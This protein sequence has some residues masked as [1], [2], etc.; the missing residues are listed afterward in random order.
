VLR[1]AC[2]AL[3]AGL[4]VSGCTRGSSD[5]DADP[6]PATSGSSVPTTSGASP[7]ATVVGL[8]P[9]PPRSA[10][11]RLAPAELTLP[12]NDSRPVPCTSP[13][14]A[15]TVHVGRLDTVVDGHSVA[16]GSATVQRQLSTA[17]PRRMAAFI[18]G[19]E[20][21]RR[22]SRF[23]VA[24]FSPTLGQS[25]RG[26]DWFRCDLVA[27]ARAE[28]LLPLPRRGTLEGVLDRPRALDTYGLCGTAAFGDPGFERVLCGR[29]HAWRAIST[30]DLPGGRRYPGAARLRA[31][32]DDVCARRARKEAAAPLRLTSGW[33]WPTRPQ[34]TSGQRYG[35]CW[36]PDRSR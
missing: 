25:D 29:P 9:P 31:A 24:W 8:P 6:S 20:K 11:Y 22:L 5:Q 15:R 17:C 2:I 4:L 26:A 7:S 32:G 1:S 34:W 35:F 27:F 12:T 30:V 19:T 36:V 21:D 10:C 33:E 23:N 3:L 28:T 14:N 13:H 16:V 18:G